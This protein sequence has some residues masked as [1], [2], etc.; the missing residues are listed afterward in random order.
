M[1]RF[2]AVAHRDQA[3]SA[4]VTVGFRMP[5]LKKVFQS[6]SSGVYLHIRRQLLTPTAVSLL[7]GNPAPGLAPDMP[8]ED[9]FL[10]VIALYCDYYKPRANKSQQPL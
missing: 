3:I 8:I 4:P 7:T 9:I 1:K 6:I 5:L 2:A 10:S